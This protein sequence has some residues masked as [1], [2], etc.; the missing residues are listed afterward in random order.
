MINILN[1]KC[2]EKW[3][4]FAPLILRVVVGATFIVAG[5]GKIQAGTEAITGFFTSV[6]IPFAG[7]M[8]PIVMWVEFLGGIALV[9][10]VWTHLV[11]KLLA[12]IMLTATLMVHL[13]NGF[14]GQGGYQLTLT[15]LAALISLMITGPG[16]FALN[17]KKSAAMPMAQ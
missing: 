1:C 8:A 4:G 2:S 6:G 9:L 10:G 12:V 15:L 14:T 13:E 3:A 16:K 17:L 11:S 5:W 7:I